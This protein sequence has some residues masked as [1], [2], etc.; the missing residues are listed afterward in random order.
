MVTSSDRISDIE[1]FFFF[2]LAC[3]CPFILLNIYSPVHLDYVEDI[4]GNSDTLGHILCVGGGGFQNDVHYL[5]TVTYAKVM[6]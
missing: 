3:V 6:N 5:Y 2:C 1:T 4:Q